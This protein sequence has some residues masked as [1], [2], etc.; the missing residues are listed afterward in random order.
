M[1]ISWLSSQKLTSGSLS[2]NTGPEGKE[3]SFQVWDQEERKRVLLGWL[4]S[5]W[6]PRPHPT[7]CSLSKVIGCRV[8]PINLQ[9]KVCIYKQFYSVQPESWKGHRML[10][11]IKRERY[12]HLYVVTWNWV[13]YS[14]VSH[15]VEKLL[16]LLS[17][18][19]CR[20]ILVCGRDEI[21]AR[22]FAY[23]NLAVGSYQKSDLSF[24][25]HHANILRREILFIDW[26]F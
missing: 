6:Y 11:L 16:A 24:W 4:T 3:S 20:T 13:S 17:F 10:P 19:L 9:L 18:P 8:L 12:H 21:Q 15:G 5:F 23:E 2:S 26:Y 14:F 1:I 7:G 25:W 22:I